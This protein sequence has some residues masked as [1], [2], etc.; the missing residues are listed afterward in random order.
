M[1]SIY[2]DEADIRA[3][4]RL[5]LGR[6]PDPSGMA[7]YMGLLGKKVSTDE[8]REFF[9]NSEE[10]HNRNLSMNQSTRVDLGGISVVV[11]PN[12]PEFGRHIA[13]YRNWEPHIVE[14]L[15]QNLSPGDVYVDIGANVGVMSFHAARIVGPAGRII[16]FEPNPDNAQNFLRGVWAN[17]FD[18]VILYQ[19]A[20]S[21]EGSIF[22]LVGSSNTW[23]SEPSISGQVAQSIRVDTLLQQESR[24]DFIKIDIEGHE[25]QALAGLIQ[26]I[27]RHQPTI[28]CE[29]NPRC[30]RDHIG[31][32][33]PLFANKLFDLTDC[34]TVVEYNGATSEV[35]NAEDLIS[36]WTRKNAEAVERG[37]LPDGML[38]FDLLFN[39]NR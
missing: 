13:K 8:L 19:F 5:F 28:L 16:A 27:K 3:A 9:V 20:A 10:F 34:I 12:E 17:K 33:P 30:L 4:Y 6:E 18:N 22:S 25:P 37:F 14:I 7:H 36:L 1:N 31:L 11:D 23:L 39:A 32:A 21:D 26:T 35:S 38:H 15:S 29:F 24:I 2:A